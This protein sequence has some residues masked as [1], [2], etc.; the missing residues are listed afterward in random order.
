MQVDQALLDV[1]PLGGELFRDVGRRD[2]AEQLAFLT[3]ACGEGEL[4][5]FEAL[6]EFARALAPLAL[7]GFETAA[8]GT[9]ALEI[10]RCGLVGETAGEQ[11]VASV[12]VLDRDDVTRMPEILDRLAQDDFH[13]MTL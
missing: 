8:F 9:D 7:G 6:R 10:A 4:H 3:D 12:A 5:L 2:R 13:G 11:E 1:E